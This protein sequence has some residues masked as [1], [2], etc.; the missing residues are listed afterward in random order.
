M[1]TKE[2]NFYLGIKR[3]VIFIFLRPENPDEPETKI[4]S[5][6]KVP[7]LKIQ[8]G[9]VTSKGSDEVGDFEFTGNYEDQYFFLQKQYLEKH[10]LFYVGKLEEQ[11]NILNLH[12]SHEENRD[13]GKEQV[14][15]GVFNALIEF[16]SEQLT[17][18]TDFCL[19][20]QSQAQEIVDRDTTI[21]AQMTEIEELK[22]AMEALTTTNE[23]L[24]TEI[25][26]MKEAKNKKHTGFDNGFG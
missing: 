10:T 6:A 18:F 26:T 20:E 3:S 5:P 21:E 16:E 14:D 1:L 8:E 7:F 4:E 25:E 15:N 13:F 19:K 2:H 12:Y 24:N 22:N 23:E 11:S 9:E 17:F